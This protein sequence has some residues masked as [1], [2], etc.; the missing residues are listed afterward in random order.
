MN[1]FSKVSI[2]KKFN[3]KFLNPLVPDIDKYNLIIRWGVVF[4]SGLSYI[5]AETEA[6]IRINPIGS[7]FLLILYNIPVSIY[8]FNRKPIEKG[9]PWLLITSDTIVSLI[10]IAFTG[11]HL[12]IFFFLLILPIIETVT[13]YKWL[14]SMTIIVIIDAL[15]LFI[16]TLT[17]SENVHPLIV[18]NRFIALLIFGLLFIIFKER[19]QIEEEKRRQIEI[20]MA[21]ERNLN[22]IF[23][24]IGESS[25][26]LEEV[27]N[28]ILESAQK[29]LD[30]S[31]AIILLN[32]NPFLRVSA[33]STSKHFIGEEIKK[34]NCKNNKD[35]IVIVEK[36]SND[37]PDF[38]KEEGIKQLICVKLSSPSQETLG[39]IVV[40]RDKTEP[41]SV[42]QLNLIKSFALEAGFAIHNSQLYRRE[43]A[44][45]K[46]LEEFEEL[47]ST[48][49]SSLGHELK[50]PITVL[51]TLSPSLKS[52][53][54]LPGDTQKEIIEIIN[55]NLNRLESLVQEMLESAR[56]ES[57]TI[58][59][60]T[61]PINI[62][63]RI[64]NVTR[65]VSPIIKRK[66]IK[67][68]KDILRDIPMINADPKRLDQIL[69]NLLNNGLKFTPQ[70]GTIKI[71][72][73]TL[74]NTVLI[75]IDDTGPGI[76]K[77]DQDR[78]F[79]KFYTSSKNKALIGVGL[80]LFI[81][82]ELVKMHGGKIWVEDSNLGGSRFCF[83]MP[84][85]K[86]SK[87]G[88]DDKKDSGH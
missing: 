67:L 13:V 6:Q 57:N 53:K 34:L 69:F 30:A 65:L 7:F 32:E 21:H 40:G 88:K 63:S 27:L 16:S 20:A 66:N 85:Y 78:I 4:A 50:T 87:N 76:S 70:G 12:S 2:G 1:P 83:T 18:I 81:C 9:N 80:G 64:D 46:K 17:T 28:I 59:L 49:F 55:Q 75:C 62:V 38:V 43:Q 19:A 45:I 26:R 60:Y 54:N 31:G 61:V 77:E 86:E 11:G 52:L 68:I 35:Q 51:K 10:V 72:I 33:S 71:S 47:R 39:W 8:I 84:I 48:F 22:E 14:I 29:L 5:F 79:D 56:L 42:Q 37:W 15:Q 41:L 74:N 24:K 82:R 73:K 25:T 58:Q 36:D 44:H 23:L 3:I